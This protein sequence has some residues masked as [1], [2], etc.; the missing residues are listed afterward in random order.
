VT[1]STNPGFIRVHPRNPRYLAFDDGDFFFP[2]GVNMGWWTQSGTALGDYARWMDDFAANGGDTIR[3]WMAEWSFGLEWYDTDLGN[4]THRLGKAWLLDQIFRMAEE[5]HMYIVLVLLNC[6]DFNSW[7]TNGWNE[8]P[9]NAVQGGPLGSP[10]E[11]VTD[12]EARA[13]LQR[14]LNYIVNRWGYSPNLLAWEWW[15]EVNLTPISD[16]ALIPWLVEMTAYL[17]ERDVNHHLTT[18]SYA[19]QYLSPIWQL[20]ELDIIQRH[21]YATQVR[22][23]DRDLAGRAAEDYGI[24]SASAP[25]KPILLGE[26]GYGVESTPDDV[27]RSGIHL[28]NGLWSTSFVGYAG[29]GMYWYWD[30]YLDAYRQWHH[31]EPLQRFLNGE[32]LTGYEPFSP[33]RISGPAREAAAVEGL[34]LRGDKTLIW[35]RSDAYTV[36]AY[37][38]AWNR[39]GSPRVFVYS[40]PLVEGLTLILDDARDGDFLVAWYDPQ[41]GTWLETNTVEARDGRLSIPI[42]AFRRDLAAKVIP[43]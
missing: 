38:D 14:K 20:P 22:S 21:E 16:E 18:N 12:P 26:F 34:G 29:A 11:F 30:V 36:Q 35:L 19:I 33:L 23:S 24:L 6:A 31:F 43:N 5:R 13:Y 15:N 40:P 2:I 8:N 37:I 4:Y 32:D 27:E 17:R 25:P 7:Q 42:P 3:V 41:K 1:P 10:T 28:H 39:A 9:Y